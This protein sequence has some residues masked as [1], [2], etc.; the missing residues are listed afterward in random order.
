M[1]LDWTTL[2]LTD[3][4]NDWLWEGITKRVDECWP[5]RWRKNNHGYSMAKFR[6]RSPQLVHRL[7]WV[8]V[9]GAI[10]NGL[11]V[12]HRC[13]HP[14]CC[15]P[16]HLFLGTHQENM[17]DRDLKGRLKTTHLCGEQNGHSVLTEND[18]LAIREIRKTGLSY[19]K[20]A[21]QFGVTKRSI[22]NVIQRRTWNHVD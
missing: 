13:D 16:T 6:G 9:H 17:K 2:N 14:W 18:V 7:V 20:I 10:P 21:D 3:K 12:L 1:S 4:E 22:I 8:S 19:Q 15:N 11:H 5:A